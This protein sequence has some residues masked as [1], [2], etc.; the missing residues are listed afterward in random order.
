MAEKGRETFF[1]LFRF[2]SSAEHGKAEA[3]REIKVGAFP[4]LCSHKEERQN[5]CGVRKLSFS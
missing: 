1:V 2:V 4:P 5:S 3:V